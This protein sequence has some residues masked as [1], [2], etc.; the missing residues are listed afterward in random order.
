M[1]QALIALDLDGT[2]L[3]EASRLPAGHERT[4]QELRRAGHAVALVTGR[5]L[6]ITEGWWRRL[7]LETPLVC[8]NGGWV[9]YPGRAPLATLR[10]SEQDT[11]DILEALRDRG[12]VACGY[13]DERRWWMDRIALETAGWSE[14]YGADIEI[15]PA[16]FLPW[17]GPSFKVMYVVDP[18][19][20][21]RLVRELRAR[22]RERFHVVQSQPDRLEILPR[23]CDKAWGL[24]RLAAH[25]GIAREQVW[26]VGDADNDLEMVRWAGHGCAMGHAPLALRRAARHLL[27]GIQARGLCALPTLLRQHGAPAGE[28]SGQDGA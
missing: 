24:R 8:F 21:P 28:D 2:L 9:G 3:D 13:P 7:R 16:D 5:P 27:P 11:R 22:F 18:A 20:T 4:V 19:H 14:R 10:L 12:G 17:C 25:L 15:R 6:L 26:A 1:A 23:G